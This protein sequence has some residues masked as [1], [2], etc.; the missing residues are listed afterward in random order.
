MKKDLAFN[1]EFH[2]NLAMTATTTPTVKEILANAAAT[3]AAYIASK[4]SPKQAPRKPLIASPRAGGSHQ[5][6]PDASAVSFFARF[7]A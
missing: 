3:S 7:P 1:S 5:I 4:A 6:T 2:Y